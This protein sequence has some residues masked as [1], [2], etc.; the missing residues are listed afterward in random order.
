MTIE[1]FN[2]TGFTGK[3][4]CTYKGEEY[5]LASVD[6]EEKLIGILLPDNEFKDDH[7]LSWV[8]C[9]NIELITN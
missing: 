2:T 6:F 4:R 8:R 5:L 3:M 9:E 1:E 7:E